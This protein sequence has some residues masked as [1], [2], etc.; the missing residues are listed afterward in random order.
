MKNSWDISPVMVKRESF[1]EKSFFFPCNRGNAKGLNHAIIPSERYK[2]S[3]PGLTLIELVT[4]ITVIGIMVVGLSMGVRAILF[5]YQNDSVLLEVRQY[6]HAVMREIMHEISTSRFIERDFANGYARLRLFQYDKHGN[7]SNIVI[8]GHALDGIQFD[9]RNPVDG[10]LG[11]PRKG[12]FRDNGQRIVRLETFRADQRTEERPNLQ[13]YAEA[14]WNLELIFS[15]ETDVN[16]QN[17]IDTRIRIRRSIFMPN[18]YI[19]LFDITK[20]GLE[21]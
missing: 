4:S 8:S 12:R 10:T 3:S 17:P 13:R 2:S 1:I 7:E 6:G 15:I 9:G 11:F 16:D 14:T 20:Q 21:S 19:S 5:H 18:K